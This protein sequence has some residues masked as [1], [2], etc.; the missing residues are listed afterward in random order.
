MEPSSKADNDVA[1][2]I[3]KKFLPVHGRPPSL[4]GFI[5]SAL[6]DAE[7]LVS[8]SR[9]T[10]I[11]STSRSSALLLALMLVSLRLLL[12]LT[13]VTTLKDGKKV[14]IREEPLWKPLILLYRKGLLLIEN[15]RNL[16]YSA[17]DGRLKLAREPRLN[18]LLGFKLNCGCLVNEDFATRGV[19]SAL[20]QVGRVMWKRLMSQLAAMPSD[21][22]KLLRREPKCLGFNLDPH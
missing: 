1:G 4:L 16:R 13:D 22:K 17:R 14:D 8:A 5:P 3:Q 18:K 15:G 2:T 6:K 21:P 20:S 9:G 7:P 12:M 11:A 19:Y 10:L